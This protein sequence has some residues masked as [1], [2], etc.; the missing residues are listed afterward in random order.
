[1]PLIR[2]LAFNVCFYLN[3]IGHLLLGLP[4]L[5]MPRH[6]L[7]ALIRSW[8]RINHW[9][10]RTLC[11][12]DFEIRGIERIPPGALLVAAKH[13]ST[14]E[15]YSLI[16]LFKDPT[17]IL[18]RELMWLP[19]FG[20]YCM[21]A[22]MIPVRRGARAAALRE[23]VEH[24]KLELAHGRQILIFPEGT[25]RPPGAAP[26]YKYGVARLY[27]DLG[28]ACLPIALNS[29]LY[30]PR[31]SWRFR[32]GKIRAQILQPIP[33]GLD[34]EKFLARL[35]SDL[36]AATARLLAEGHAELGRRKSR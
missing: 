27:A 1:V 28:V 2:A 14:W 16:P 3:T 29:G 15:T 8:A 19:V 34:P 36:E 18:K 30:W 20:W 12:I 6:A 21:K 9:L 25:R 32:P 26:D 24:A 10:L 23:M 4:V 7:W 17:F 11:G 31:R 33:P 13:Q 22:R 35:Q 5:T